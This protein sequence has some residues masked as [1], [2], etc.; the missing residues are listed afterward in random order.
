MQPKIESSFF[1]F[2]NG[3]EI[4][5]KS[6]LAL[7]VE[8]EYD[9]AKKQIAEGFRRSFIDNVIASATV[10]RETF[11]HVH[12]TAHIIWSE[13]LVSSK[14]RELIMY[15]P[16]VEVATP[17]VVSSLLVAR[18]I[19]EN[20][21]FELYDVFSIKNLPLTNETVLA[22]LEFEARLGNTHDTWLPKRYRNG[23]NPKSGCRTQYAAVARQVGD[24][25]MTYSIIDCIPMNVNIDCSGGGGTTVNGGQPSSPGGSSSSGGRSGGGGGSPSGGGRDSDQSRYRDNAGTFMWKPSA[26][27]YDE[28]LVNCGSGDF[29]RIIKPAIIGDWGAPRECNRNPDIWLDRMDKIVIKCP[30]GRSTEIRTDFSIWNYEC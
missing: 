23:N 24:C 6:P 17:N 13:G 8:I 16:I 29:H 22:F 21:V 19:E 14:Y 28:N 27:W 18:E 20:F 1:S 9:L 26:S 11:V 12:N 10:E 3:V 25:W 30:Q 4:F 7:P 2:E 5:D 15:F